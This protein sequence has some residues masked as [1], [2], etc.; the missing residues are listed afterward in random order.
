[1]YSRGLPFNIVNDP[2]WFSM[3]DIVANFRLGFK[4]PSMH[5]L[6]TWIL[7]EEV[8]DLSII[9]EDHKKAWKQYGFSIMSDGW[10]DGKN[11]C[12]INFFAK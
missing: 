4:P 2:Y 6:R 11:R 9:M 12:L 1:M 8:D 10:K 3:M 5:E 7:K